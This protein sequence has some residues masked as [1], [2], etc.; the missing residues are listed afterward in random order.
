MNI[1]RVLR[2]LQDDVTARNDLIIKKLIQ[3]QLYRLFR[4]K[5]KQLI[6]ISIN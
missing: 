6:K 1:S 2:L 3:D 5:K 4:R